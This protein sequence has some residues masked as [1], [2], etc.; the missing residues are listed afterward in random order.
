MKKLIVKLKRARNVTINWIVFIVSPIWILPTLIVLLLEDL[1]DNDQSAKR[2][3][4]GQD[5]IFG[6][7]DLTT[8]DLRNE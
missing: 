8:K 3:V 5:C 4:N 1:K 7:F 6:Y 2:Y